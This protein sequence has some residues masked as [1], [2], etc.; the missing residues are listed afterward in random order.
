MKRGLHFDIKLNSR[1]IQK[2]NCF[3][4]PSY[5]LFASSGKAAFPAPTATGVHRLRN[6]WSSPRSQLVNN[7]GDNSAD[8]VQPRLV[9]GDVGEK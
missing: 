4:V 3:L 7:Y 9:G 1:D 2:C 8:N 6:K 5:D